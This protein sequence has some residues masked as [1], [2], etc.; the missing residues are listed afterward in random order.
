[1][2][3]WISL[4]DAAKL[5]QDGQTIA[6]GGMTMYRR[7]VGFV[8]EL[9]RRQIRPKDLTLLCFTAGFESDLLVGAGCVRTVRSCYFG[10]ESF[11]FAPMFTEAAQ[12]STIEI[13]EETETS[14]AM[15]IRAGM[16]G[17]GFM[18]SRAWVGTSLPSL[19]P[20]VKTVVDPYSGETLMAFP[21]IHC[22]VAILHGLEGDKAGNI[23]INNNVGVDVEL[24]YLA[25]TVI[26]TVE[27]MVEKVEKSTDA[28]LIPAP[29]ASYI[30]HTPRGA[31]PTSCYPDYPL[32][33]NEFMRYVDA[34]NA[35]QFDEYLS[36]FLQAE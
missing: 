25:D 22:D 15:G 5:I 21:A 2:S 27:R 6:L 28:L 4:P 35:G 20:D 8:R 31:W 30:V 11:G 12:K 9:L 24:V 36:A 18:P 33:G 1:M 26:V 23:K 34:C 14:L 19:R 29:G 3:Q 16:S 10:L 32:G 13:M 17:V 7:P